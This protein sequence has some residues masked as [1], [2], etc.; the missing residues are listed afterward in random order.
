M[1]PHNLSLFTPLNFRKST[2]VYGMGHLLLVIPIDHEASV[3]I[4]IIINCI[5]NLNYSIVFILKIHYII[6]LFIVL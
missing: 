6:T 4:I 2:T 1:P 3:I 5:F